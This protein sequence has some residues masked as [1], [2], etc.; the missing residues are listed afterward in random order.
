MKKG[1]GFTILE[2][3]IVLGILGILSVALTAAYQSFQRAAVLDISS[4]QIVLKLREAQARALNGED[5]KRWGIR[6]D[7]SLLGYRLFSTLTTFA[8]GVVKDTSYL[9]S[10]VEYKTFDS[11]A[12]GTPL[13]VIFE[14]ITGIP[15]GG[16]AHS[17]EINLRGSPTFS[18]LITVS[19]S[20]RISD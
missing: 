18:K 14:R 11:G 7:N 19:S 12:V 10:R 13:D 5:G 16:I 6:F 8:S 17:V 20:G 9:E 2:I 1:F 3:I 15:S 4:R